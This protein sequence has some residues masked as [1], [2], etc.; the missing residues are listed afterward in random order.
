VWVCESCGMAPSKKLLDTK[1]PIAILAH[2]LWHLT[3][4]TRFGTARNS[5]RSQSLPRRVC[6][7]GRRDE[8]ICGLHLRVRPAEMQDT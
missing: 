7:Y 5:S 6:M 3:F 1:A 2:P 4:G 8:L